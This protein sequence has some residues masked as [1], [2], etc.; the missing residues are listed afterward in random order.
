MAA[1]GAG[2]I[3]C[4]FPIVERP[5]P[6]CAVGTLRQVPSQECGRFRPFL[7]CVMWLRNRGLAGSLGEDLSRAG[8]RSLSGAGVMAWSEM[9][10][11]GD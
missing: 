11:S 2:L 3:C 1:A 6:V 5:Q 4:H 9:F 7:P 10:F 8:L